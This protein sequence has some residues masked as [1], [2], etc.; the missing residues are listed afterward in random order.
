MW[1]YIVEKT[2]IEQ[3]RKQDR[4]LIDWYLVLE[5]RDEMMGLLESEER[6][7]ERERRIRRPR[8]YVWQ[9]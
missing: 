6:E 3:E 9:R 5:F 1:W 7:R 4:E 8:C 2:K